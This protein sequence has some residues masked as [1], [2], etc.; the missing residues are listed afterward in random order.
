MKNNYQFL[1]KN[2]VFWS[3]L[4]SSFDPPIYDENG[5]LFP[6]YSGEDQKTIMR[7]NKNFA[8]AGVKTF[9][10]ALHLGW[11]GENK[12]DYSL[13][14]ATLE[15]VFSE[16]EDIFF[17]PRIKLNVPVEW[18]YYHPE[19]VCVYYGGPDTA[20]KIKKLVGTPKHDYLGYESPDG[21]Y[22]AG[23]KVDKRPNVGGVIARQS[24]SSKQWKHDAGEALI[25]LI[26]RIENGKYGDRIIGY[27]IA[28]GV[29]G[30]TC[31][32]GRFASP[33][34]GDYGIGH[35]R[36]FLK[37]AENKYG[38][39]DKLCKAWHLKDIKNFNLPSPEQREGKTAAFDKF[40]RKTDEDKIC[41][42][43]D[44]F[45]SKVNADAIEYF[46]K[47]VKEN[48]QNKLVG[49][50]YGYFLHIDNA[51]YTGHLEIERLLNSPYVDFFAAPKPYFRCINGEPGGEMCPSLSINRKKVWF[52]E[53]DIRTFLAKDAPD[54]WASRTPEDT[55]TILWRELSKN[56][57]H[58]SGF[59]WM[60]LGVGWYESDILMNEIRRLVNIKDNLI[61]KPK[62]NIG[63]ILI[64][65]DEDSCNYIRVNHDFR[66]GF[67]ENFISECNLTGA[68][69]EVYR[70]KDLKELD[71]SRYKLIVF[72]YTFKIDN[73][74][75]EIIKKNVTKD[76][77]MMFN[78][79]SGLYKEN[80]C[81]FDN[82]KELTGFD[83]S[84]SEKDNGYGFPNLSVRG[85]KPVVTD[86]KNAAPVVFE[87]K[88]T[89]G[90]KN[91]INLMPYLNSEHIR[92][93]AEKSGC[94]MYTDACNV[95]VYGDNRFIAFFPKDSYEGSIHFKE[96]E[97]LK[98]VLHNA[99]YSGAD[100]IKVHLGKCD[101]A[102]F[103]KEN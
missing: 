24:F 22:T 65:V 37:W 17:I 3:C 100:E 69:A 70:L 85:A 67:M 61:E 29:S 25:R 79:A 56:L 18:C 90:G 19:D 75:R 92:A 95:T 10:S 94:H 77:N 12:Y 72:A 96:R 1:R 28:Y 97:K 84:V 55:I 64:L 50:F 76:V 21:V 39:E 51:A 5:K 35:K 8:K 49:I 57:A 44:L 82:C 45:S 102:F 47:L 36:E 16:N 23:K 31:V 73:E 66:C 40:V 59:W 91:Y 81:S 46:G 33:H 78:W 6:L 58:G 14:D 62:K 13:T 38:G 98:D 53:T 99:K 42:D 9:S 80:S 20:D 68:I 54:Y 74:I 101:A 34:K 32:W 27:H 89:D 43:Y 103:I 93:I 30:E 71:L 48:T 11:V 86:K 83:L 63:D 87:M 41:I 4:G 60:D 15:K 52:D 2:S 88:R 7:S 26:K